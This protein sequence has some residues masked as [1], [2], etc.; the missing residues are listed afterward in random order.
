MNA[1]TVKQEK[2]KGLPIIFGDASQE[3]ILETVHLSKARDS[4]IRQ[5]SYKSHY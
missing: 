3:H 4:N 1:E 2:K 5:A